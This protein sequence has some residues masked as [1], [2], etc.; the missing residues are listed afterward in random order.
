MTRREE[1]LTDNV[2]IVRGYIK[3]LLES[4]NGLIDPKVEEDAKKEFFNFSTVHLVDE[5]VQTTKDYPLGHAI[6]VKFST[7][8][9]VMD[10]KYFAELL[11]GF[12]REIEEI[13][14]ERLNTI[15]HN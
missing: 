2:H 1:I 14:L 12:E 10:R 13:N 4:T 3:R 5:L 8:I 11:E 6:P 7:D 9:I 15:Q